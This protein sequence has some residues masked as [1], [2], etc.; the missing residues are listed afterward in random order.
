MFS[1]VTIHGITLLD[2]SV[3]FGSKCT[4]WQF[5][6]ICAGTVVGD[7]VVIGSN[8]WIGKNCVIGSGTRIQHGAF[9]PNG[10]TIGESVFIGPNV[11]LTDDK[12]PS[13]NKTTPY[14]AQPPVLEHLCSLGA[15]CVVLP[16]LTIGRGAMVGAGAVVT[17]HVKPFETVLSRQDVVRKSVTV[18]DN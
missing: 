8:V 18:S 1:H 12:Y 10:T 16:G 9:I 17:S 11:T 14:V 2:V 7:N 3:Q 6:T 15:G 4:V 13:C 5:S